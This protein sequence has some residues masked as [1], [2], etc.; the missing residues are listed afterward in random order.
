MVALFGAGGWWCTLS[1]LIDRV[2][3]DQPCEGVND[4]LEFRR[5]ASLKGSQI[6]HGAVSLSAESNSMRFQPD[7]GSLAN[8][9]ASKASMSPTDSAST[10]DGVKP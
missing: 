3:Q 7:S 4:L 6:D 5:D 1:A 8:G 9:V 10:A 2:H